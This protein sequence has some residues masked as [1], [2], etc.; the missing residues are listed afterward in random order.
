MSLMPVQEAQGR[1]AASRAT[2]AVDVF[3]E[4]SV[5]SGLGRQHTSHFFVLVRGEEGLC[6]R[7]VPTIGVAAHACYEVQYRERGPEVAARVLA[8]MVRVER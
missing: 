7:I 4:G 3:R 8:T 1:V 5:R 2:E 6:D